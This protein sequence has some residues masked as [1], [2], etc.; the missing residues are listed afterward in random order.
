MEDTH[1]TPYARLKPTVEGLGFNYL[2]VWRAHK[3]GMFPDGVITRVGRCLFVHVS[4]FED[5]MA[6]GGV[7]LPE[8]GSETKAAAAR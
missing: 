1:S 8:S 6:Q 7:G 2:T 4:R 5:V 3:L